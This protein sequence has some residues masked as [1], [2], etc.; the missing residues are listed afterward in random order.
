VNIIILV[1]LFVIAIPVLWV[2]WAIFYVL[3]IAPYKKRTSYLVSRAGPREPGDGFWFTYYEKGKELNFFGED[4][5]NTIYVPNEELW[6]NTMPD[7]FRDRYNVIIDRLKRKMGRRMSLKI[8]DDY[9]QG[10]SILYVDYSKTGSE[11]TIKFGV[12]PDD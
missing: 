2:G 3:V 10:G 11:R 9:N 4:P 12:W 5:E 8:V 1:I 7:F 6:K